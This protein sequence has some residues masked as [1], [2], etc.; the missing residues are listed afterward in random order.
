LADTD[1]AQRAVFP[2]AASV[3]LPIA[4]V[5]AVVQLLAAVFGHGYWFD[6]IY[7]LAN[8]RNHLAWG[9]ADQP[10]LAPALAA[11]ADAIAP[12]SIVALRVPAILA[13][14]AAVVVA[15]LIARELG[16]IAGLKL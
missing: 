12:G 6:E 7:M 8:G 14:S 16:A 10:P 15:A 11:V 2:F 9:L 1:T 13:T 3:V 4:G 5:V